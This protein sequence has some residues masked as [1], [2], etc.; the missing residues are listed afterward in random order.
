MSVC[1][2]IQ[3]SEKIRRHSVLSPILMK[4]AFWLV[5]FCSLDTA[6]DHML[7]EKVNERISIHQTQEAQCMK[8]FLN[9]FQRLLTDNKGFRIN[10]FKRSHC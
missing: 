1:Y 3:K 7:R 5:F 6:Y 2:Q 10:V 4:Q 9:T 8:I